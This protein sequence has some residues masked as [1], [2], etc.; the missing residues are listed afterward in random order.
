LR[1][2]HSDCGLDRTE[3]P[4]WKADF[5]VPGALLNRHKPLPSNGQKSNPFAFGDE[6]SP[7][8]I[9]LELPDLR[10]SRKLLPDVALGTLELARIRVTGVALPGGVFTD[11]PDR[12]PEELGLLLAQT[13]TELIE[14]LNALGYE[15][16][17]ALLRILRRVNLRDG[18]IKGL[19][20][21]GR[22]KDPLLVVFFKPESEELTPGKTCFRRR[23][24]RESRRRIRRQKLALTLLRC[25]QIRRGAAH[26]HT[27]LSALPSL[28]I[29]P[30]CLAKLLSTAG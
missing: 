5:S 20:D 18:L 29:W 21:T 22:G 17:Q 25:P 15:L 19:C 4:L 3:K 16:C 1:F 6:E 9:W 24:A 11:P 10:P 14:R 2:A 27:P 13:L 30:N 8:L 26:L 7:E 12:F 23:I 28:R